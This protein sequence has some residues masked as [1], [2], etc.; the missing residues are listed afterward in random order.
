MRIC[1]FC[2]SADNL[3]PQI[4]QAAA[5]LGAAIGSRGHELVFGG[6]ETGLM[7][8]V[9]RSA[10]RAGARVVGVIP[11][12]QGALPGRHAFACDEL[13]ETEGLQARKACME[14][15][16]DA[17]VALPGSYGTLDE[18]YNVLSAQKLMGGSKPIA[19]LNVGGFYDP[20]FEMHRRMVREGTMPQG[21]ADR[22]MEFSEV[23]GLMDALERIYAERG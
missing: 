17:F 22:C 6:F 11:C 3:S 2:S 8:E 7:G 23:G 1:V 5:E 14:D 13:V 18:L 12:R 21:N 4:V 19:V 15:L 9:A 20:L 10:A 16:S